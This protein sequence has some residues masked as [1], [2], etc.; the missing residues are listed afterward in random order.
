M[1]WEDFGKSKQEKP[2]EIT[3]RKTNN[4]YY[5]IFRIGKKYK[6][7]DGTVKSTLAQIKT[8]QRHM[9]REM[10]VPNA[11][12]NICNE[13]LIG[14]SDVY[15]SAW[16][17]IQGIKLRKNNIVARELLL[18]ASPNFFKGLSPMD[19]DKWKNV[20]INWLE[21]NFGTN[22]IYATLHKDESTW[23]IHAL[24]IPKF[25]NKRGKYILSN[26]RYFDGIEKLRGWQDNYA[27]NMRTHFKSL[28]RGIKY[29]KAKHMEIKHF[30]SLI[31][32]NLNEKDIDQLASKAKNAE[33][34]NIKI[35]AIEKTLE[36]YRQLNSSNLEEKEN[37]KNNFKKL[38]KEIDQIKEDKE[39]YKEAIEMLSQQYK[40]PQYAVKNA[41]KFCQNINQRERY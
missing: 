31:N 2:K 27:N 37:I 15:R 8:F 24:I 6:T 3:Y 38:K 34:L 39:L 23:H 12:R 40:I 36:L 20:N 19:L 4:Y 32:K 14:N 28:N 21:E 10:E 22:C 9:E 16:N 41:I 18:T 17:Y 30:Y 35:K 7:T 26:T 13:I 5:A 1:S 29:S 11:N 33:L 25:E